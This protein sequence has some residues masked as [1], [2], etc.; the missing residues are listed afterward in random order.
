MTQNMPFGMLITLSQGVIKT[1]QTPETFTSPLTTLKNLDKGPSPPKE[2]LLE[3]NFY[4]K[5]LSVWE[6]KHLITKHMLFLWSCE[7]LIPL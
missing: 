7:L 3:I 1:Q 5:A 6:G 4:L 2:L